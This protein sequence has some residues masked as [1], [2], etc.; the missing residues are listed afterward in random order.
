MSLLEHRLLDVQDDDEGGC[1]MGPDA[2]QAHDRRRCDRSSES[3]KDAP[4]VERVADPPKQ[5]RHDQG[6]ARL[7]ARPPVR[8]HFRLG[9]ERD[10]GAADEKERACGQPDARIAEV[11]LGDGPD[12]AQDGT[13]KAEEAPNSACGLAHGIDSRDGPAPS[14]VAMARGDNRAIAERGKQKRQVAGRGKKLLHAT[15]MTAGS[16]RKRVARR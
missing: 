13:E 1:E 16:P 4:Q 14:G 12:R 2:Q 5:P 6:R 8:A 9:R 3:R 7:H 10:D 11:S 15:M